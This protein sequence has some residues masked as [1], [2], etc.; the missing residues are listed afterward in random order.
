MVHDIVGTGL[1]LALHDK[2]MFCPSL[3]V[4]PIG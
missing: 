1:P 4:T 2:V 3:I